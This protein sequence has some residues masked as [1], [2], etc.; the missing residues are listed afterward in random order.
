MFV[1]GSFAVVWI[2]WPAGDRPRNL[3]LWLTAYALAMASTAWRAGRRS[4]TAY[5]ALPAA[6]DLAGSVLWSA[7]A[8]RRLQGPDDRRRVGLVAALLLGA[9]AVDRSTATSWYA[10]SVAN[11]PNVAAVVATSAMVALGTGAIVVVWRTVGRPVER[12]RREQ[13]TYPLAAA[14][15]PAAGTVL[16]ARGLTI[17]LI[18][19]QNLVVLASDPFSRG[20]DLFGTVYWQ[21]SQQPISPSASGII[22]AGVLLAGHVASL[23]LIGRAATA[24]TSDGRSSLQ[25]RKAAWHAALPA[26][27]AVSLAG[28]VWTLVLL[29]Q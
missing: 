6:L 3:A 15:A 23:F 17:G 24:R 11:L 21:V 27:A 18:Q 2:A 5:D 7:R 4:L 20:W 9:I 26:M 25:F 13:R 29:G 14:L 19:L 10:S 12:R 1:L 16:L 22:Q 8:R 28:I